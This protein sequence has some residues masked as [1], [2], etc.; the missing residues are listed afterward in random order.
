MKAWQLR[1]S[2]SAHDNA[3]LPFTI[4]SLQARDQEF[5]KGGAQTKNF[6]LEKFM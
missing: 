2:Q 5:N 6:L 1:N 3:F 4:D